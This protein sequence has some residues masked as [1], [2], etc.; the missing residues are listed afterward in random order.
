MIRWAFLETYT[1][2]GSRRRAGALAARARPLK[3]SQSRDGNHRQKK[4]GPTGE[5][6]TESGKPEVRSRQREMPMPRS[7]GV[8][9][10]L[11]WPVPTAL[12]TAAYPF[13][14]S[15]LVGLPSQVRPK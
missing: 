9:L 14:D 13:T 5:S 15:A 1:S 4:W 6:P 7:L 8:V 3:M 2:S 12:G 10:L 11:T